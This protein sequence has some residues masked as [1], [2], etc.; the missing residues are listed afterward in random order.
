MKRLLALVIAAAVVFSLA[1]CDVLNID[2]DP[3]GTEG[4]QTPALTPTG[5]ATPE[6]TPTPSPTQTL[7]P[8]P[9]RIPSPTPTMP[10]EQ[11]EAQERYPALLGYCRDYL[12]L[13]AAAGIK[14]MYDKGYVTQQQLEALYDIWGEMRDYDEEQWTAVQDDMRLMSDIVNGRLKEL[15]EDSGEKFYSMICTA[16]QQGAAYIN[17]FDTQQKQ[18]RMKAA[19]DLADKWYSGQ[20]DGELLNLED[21]YYSEDLTPGETA[22]LGYYICYSKDIPARI[23]VNGTVV[24]T[25]KY[26][27]ENGFLEYADNAYYKLIDLNNK[28]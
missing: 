5:T 10:P 16:P 18:D 23:Q 6:S 28:A 17:L 21:A 7:A 22:M 25:L 20:T 9:T 15:D 1:A 2:T 12:D 26:I 11:A 13:S 8:S 4:L 14:A 27:S 24:E 3:Y 19:I